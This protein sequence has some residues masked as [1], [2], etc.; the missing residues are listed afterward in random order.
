[1]GMA[2]A[3][4]KYFKKLSFLKNVIAQHWK[5]YF[6]VVHIKIWSISIAN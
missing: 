3:H 5:S 2:R 6:E 4:N 1:M